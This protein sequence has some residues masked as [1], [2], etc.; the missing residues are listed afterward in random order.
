MDYLGIIKRAFQITIKHKF[1]WI[2]G[3]LAAFTEGGM[4]NINLGNFNS[5]DINNFKNFWQNNGS[6][7]S[8]QI[9][10]SS[11]VKQKILG[12]STNSADIFSNLTNWFSNNLTLI[13]I[14]GI[15][16]IILMILVLVVSEMAKGGLVWSVAEINKGEKVGLRQ[17]FKKGF[18]IFWRILGMEIILGLVSLA[19]LMIFAVPIIYLAV[20]KVY[21]GAIIWGILFFIPMLVFMIFL[22]ILKQ[23]ALRNIAIKSEGAYDSLKNAYDLFKN[24]LKSVLAIWLLAV[25]LGIGIGIITGIILLFVV[26][27]LG[28]IGFGIYFLAGAL[29][30]AIAAVFLFLV[31]LAIGFLVS[32]IIQAFISSYWT[33]AYIELKK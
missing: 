25:G 1:L 29:G 7:P 32:G 31:L 18:A 17:S 30:A 27:I 11:I 19:A 28:A 33:L 14:I 13:I 26:F 9:P 15:I 5:T 12:N 24:K 16:I 4:V 2:L 20:F 21:L 22:T 6:S 3:F 23:Y 8:N 10:A